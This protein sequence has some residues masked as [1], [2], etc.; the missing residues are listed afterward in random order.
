MRAELAELHRELTR[1]EALALTGRTT[2]AAA[3]GGVA[4]GHTHA[5]AFHAPPGPFDDSLVDVALAEAGGWAPSRYGAGDE[6]GTLNEITPRKTARALRMLD[7]AR[8][9]KTYDLSELLRNGFPAFA[10]TPPR[11]YEQRLALN[12]YSPPPGFEGIV[13]GT[14]PISV[15]R[16]STNEE[17]FPLGGTYQIGT[18]LDNLNHIGV[19]DVY[20][21]GFRGPEIARTYGTER[22]GAEKIG[23]LVTR[24]VL[25]DVLTIKVIERQTQ[26]LSEAANGEPVLRDDYRITIEDL[27]EAMSFGRIRRIEPGD[28]VLIRTGWNQVGYTDPARFLAKEPGIYLREARWLA[29]FRPAIVGSDTWG[30]ELLGNPVVQGFAQVHQELITHH[31]IRILES[32]VLDELARDRVYTFVFLVTPQKPLGATATNAGPAALAPLG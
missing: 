1:R 16:L 8:R 7:G 4:L 14:Q 3:I 12:G 25:L 28:V 21:N 6:R 19:G 29:T 10:T 17:R 11:I 2:A 23:P 22:L 9:V 18:Q 20:Y 30:G 5:H 32:A 24:G 13:Q 15:N 31:G 26:A 27:E